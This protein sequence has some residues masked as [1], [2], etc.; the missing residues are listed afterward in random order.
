MI[1][2]FEK[3]SKVVNVVYQGGSYSLSDV[4]DIFFYYFSAYD[5]RLLGKQAVAVG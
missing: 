3:F 1:F 5:Y 4:L 2:N